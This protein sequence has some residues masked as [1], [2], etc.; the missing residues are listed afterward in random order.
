MR[1]KTAR[2]MNTLN[3]PSRAERILAVRFDAGLPDQHCAASPLAGWSRIP[4]R[5]WRRFPRSPRGCIDR[6]AGEDAIEK[7]DVV[8]VRASEKFVQFVL[9]QSRMIPIADARRA[10]DDCVRSEEVASVCTK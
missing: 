9:A 4:A 5:E 1:R 8:L 2:E 7:A 6:R 10:R 3:S